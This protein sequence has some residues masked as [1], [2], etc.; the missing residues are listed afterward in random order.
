M[1]GEAPMLAAVCSECAVVVDSMVLGG[2]REVTCVLVVVFTEDADGEGV[3]LR[4]TAVLSL[5]SLCDLRREV[6]RCLR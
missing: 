3:F 6:N 5:W 4:V 2:E 1:A